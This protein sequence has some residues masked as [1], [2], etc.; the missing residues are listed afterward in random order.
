MLRAARALAL[1]ASLAPMDCTI[2]P[3]PVVT[4]VEADPIA[5]AAVEA[6]TGSDSGE[7]SHTACIKQCNDNGA[8]CD[9]QCGQVS[10]TACDV[11]CSQAFYSCKAMCDGG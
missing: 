6:E 10:N 7:A 2:E 4:E 3:A 9:M 8:V 11:M 1:L 5:D